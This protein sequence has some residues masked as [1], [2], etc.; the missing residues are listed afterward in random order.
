[1]ATTP[2]IGLYKP[3]RDDYVSV[4]RDLSNNYELIDDAIGQNNTLINDMDIIVNGN[5]ASVN[6]T[7]GQ[8]VTVRN[9]TI[10][11]I[12]DGIYKAKV[13]VSSG[14]SFTSSNLEN[15]TGGALNSLNEKFAISSYTASQAIT[16]NGGKGSVAGTDIVVRKNESMCQFFINTTGTSIENGNLFFT[17]ANLGIRPRGVF[18]AQLIN[19]ATYKPVTNGCVYFNTNGEVR[20]YGDSLSNLGLSISATYIPF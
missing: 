14:T 4:Q 16:M 13:N 6:V 1:M 11:G 12:T 7:A 3:T 2:N 15:I 20:Y 19:T 8:F 5:T 17:I 10:A 9:S 18:Y